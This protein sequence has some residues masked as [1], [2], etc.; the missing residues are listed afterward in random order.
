MGWESLFDGK[1]MDQWR[2]YQEEDL[3]GWEI[4]DDEMIALGLEEGHADIITK[5]IYT[6]FE[7][8]LEWNISQ[9]GNSGIFFNVAEEEELGTVYQSGP[10]YQLADDLSLAK[11]YNRTRVS[12]ANY[13]M[14]APRLNVA[15]PAGQW[16]TTRLIVDEGH[17]QHWL[18]GK[19]V[20]AY[21]LWTPEWEEIKKNSK[22]SFYP[23]YGSYTSGHIALQDHGGQIRFRNVKLRRL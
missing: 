14:H 13:D 5:E 2:V 23:K 19:K 17:V 7:L 16:N 18:N 6:N 3:R 21:N 1:T 9:G 8:R 10:E 11:D 15:K 4:R 22:W 12:G 20:V